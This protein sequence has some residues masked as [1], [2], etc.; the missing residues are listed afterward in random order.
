MRILL[1]ALLPIAL[2]GCIST[3]VAAI[4]YAEREADPVR[5]AVQA[6]REFALLAQTTGQWTAFRATAAADATMF[7][8][9]PVN[10]QTWLAGRADPPRSVA[11]QPHAVFVSC[12]GRMAATT[13]AA[14]WPGGGHGMFTTIWQKQPDGNWKWIADHGAPVSAARA[15]RPAVAEVRARCARSRTIATPA[16]LVRDASDSVGGV[17][18]R[19]HDRVEYRPIYPKRVEETSAVLERHARECGDDAPRA[20]SART[21]HPDAGVA[22]SGLAWAGPRDRT[23]D[24]MRRFQPDA[25]QCAL[26]PGDG[27]A[28]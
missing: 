19:R 16:A 11:W 13:G 5:Q 15:A 8:P 20:E 12:D 3:G 4:R 14:Q 28:G 1:L 2:S 7:V 24:R 6:E 18:I 26:Q 22:R 25:R 23:G 10:A 27:Q 17:V 21:C 9:Q